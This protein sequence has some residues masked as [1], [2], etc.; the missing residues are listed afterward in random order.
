MDIMFKSNKFEKQCNEFRL[1]VAQHGQ[2]RAKKIRQRLDELSAASSLS[3]VSR[4]PPARCH[5]LIGDRAGQLSVDLDHPYRLIFSPAHDPVPRKEDG[6]L[7]LSKVTAVVV[8]G[9]EDTHE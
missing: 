7:D 1:L 8:Q 5:E 9:I 2:P 4:L 6:G 3:E